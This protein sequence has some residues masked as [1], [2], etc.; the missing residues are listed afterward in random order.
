VKKVFILFFIGIFMVSILFL[1]SGCKTTT[2]TETTAAVTT[3]AETTAATTA[4]ET[5]AAQETIKTLR[6]ALVWH[7][8]GGAFAPQ[9]MAGM[10]AAAKEFGVEAKWYGIEKA[11][12]ELQVKVIE[13]LLATGIDG[14]AFSPVDPKATN[15]VISEVIK[16]GIPLLTFN[17]D[18]PD[19]ERMG[20]IGQ[21]HYT[22]GQAVGENLKPFLEGKEGSVSIISEYPAMIELQDRAKGEQDAIKVYN[23]NLKFLEI[24]EIGA[25]LAKCYS[26]AETVLQGNPDLVA[27][28]GVG[29]AGTPTAGQLALNNGLAGKLIVGGFDLLP[30]TLDL[31]DK[32]AIQVT[33]GQ[34]PYGQGYE[35]VR[36][37]YDYLVNKVEI[38][39]FFDTGA[40][41]VTK[42]N[43]AKYLED[44]KKS[45]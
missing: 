32:G 7:E 13:D 40:E 41:V 23:S 25:D 9:I 44:L 34:N 5:T 2:V 10:E 28:L 20:Y 38:P 29:G 39:K 16:K 11:D 14:I 26:I 43:V 4:A 3:A 37:L 35:S 27:M 17:S 18:A 21:S 8:Q 19:S 24:V 6:I 36:I 31:V 45:Q 15:A 22:A 33:V 42:D 12:P 30:Q 1:G